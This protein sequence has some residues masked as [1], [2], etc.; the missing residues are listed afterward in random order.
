MQINEIKQTVAMGISCRRSQRASPRE[1]L[2]DNTLKQTTATGVS[3]I[4]MGSL[5]K[6][7]QEG[8]SA[9]NDE[10]ILIKGS[11][12]RA[13]PGHQPPDQTDHGQTGP[14]GDALH[15]VL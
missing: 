11:S 13:I 3:A 6:E 2:G 4:S 10:D 15:V 5:G 9:L 8:E 7:N 12:G 1:D 14:C